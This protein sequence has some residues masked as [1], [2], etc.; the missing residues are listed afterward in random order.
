VDKQSHVL[1]LD[2][3][4]DIVVFMNFLIYKEE[5]LKEARK[6]ETPTPDGGEPAQTRLSFNKLHGLPIPAAHRVILADQSCAKFAQK[7]TGA[8]AEQLRQ[9]G[10]TARCTEIVHKGGIVTIE[11]FVTDFD[12]G[13]AGGSPLFDCCSKGP[14]SKGDGENAN[15]T[16][17]I[18]STMSKKLPAMV[19]ADAP[20]GIKLELDVRDKKDQSAMSDAIFQELHAQPTM[21]LCGSN[22]TGCCIS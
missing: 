2:T 12:R 9:L 14:C 21:R 4:D 5:T 3:S 6:M 19:L 18:V 11:A 7:L 8:V 15:V 16:H 17:K 13:K 20:A 1:H 10:I 22:S